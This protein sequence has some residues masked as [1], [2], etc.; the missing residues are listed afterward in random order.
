MVGQLDRLIMAGDHGEDVEEE[1]EDDLQPIF[2]DAELAEI[3]T[4]T[5]H[6]D[7]DN[8][9]K[10]DQPEISGIDTAPPLSLAQAEKG[11]FFETRGNGDSGER[12]VPF[13]Y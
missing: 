1:E 11:Y 12:Y 6:Q 8:E 2:N 4:L 3:S 7:R 10:A 13:R 5:G 9:G